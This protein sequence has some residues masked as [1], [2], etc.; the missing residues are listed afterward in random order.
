MANFKSHLSAAANE[1]RFQVCLSWP[2]VSLFLH[3]I[4]N[5]DL[6]E[7][8]NY[9]SLGYY[10]QCDFSCAALNLVAVGQIGVRMSGTDLTF[11]NCHTW[12]LS[13]ESAGMS[14]NTMNIQIIVLTLET[15]P[16]CKH[17]YCATAL[18]V[19]MGLGI[20]VF[21]YSQPIGSYSLE[22]FV[23]KYHCFK[24]L[25]AMSSVQSKQLK[26][27]FAVVVDSELIY[28]GS[29]SYSQSLARD[30]SGTFYFIAVVVV[31][32]KFCDSS[33]FVLFLNCSFRVAQN[34]SAT[35]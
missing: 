6:F 5:T 27:C 16:L 18:T 4:L 23:E 28:L 22:L 34:T 19:A 14:P 32:L 10:C 12:S 3:L 7:A 8:L 24:T 11:S 21:N 1:Q 33:S 35:R 15:G 9:N 31:T 17:S 26:V 20:E 2:G 25:I 13:T 30:C 29:S